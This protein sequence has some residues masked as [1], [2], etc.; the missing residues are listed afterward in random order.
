MPKHYL[1]LAILLF[2]V[3]AILPMHQ[4]A[5]NAANQ[6]EQVSLRR[7][8]AVSILRNINTVEVVYHPSMGLTVAGRSC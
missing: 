6:T 4:Y 3:T 5:Q 7:M 1:P 8:M 2:G